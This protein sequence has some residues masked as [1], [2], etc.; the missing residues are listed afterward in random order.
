MSGKIDAKSEVG[1]TS[2]GEGKSQLCSAKVGLQSPVGDI[3][4]LHPT[5]NSQSK[6]VIFSS[7]QFRMLLVHCDTL[8]W[9]E[10][11]YEGE[12]RVKG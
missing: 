3:Y 1:K 5:K 8:H 11:S 2:S 6:S 12:R 7:L 4:H 10:L 9:G